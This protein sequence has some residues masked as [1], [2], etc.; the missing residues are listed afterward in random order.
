[1]NTSTFFLTELKAG[2]LPKKN[3]VGLSPCYSRKC[4]P[5]GHSTVRCV[6]YLKTSLFSSGDDFTPTGG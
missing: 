6:Q 5:I 2:C 4:V 3:Q 1:M